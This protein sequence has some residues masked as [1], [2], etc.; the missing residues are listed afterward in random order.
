MFPLTYLLH[1]YV[2]KFVKR[3]DRALPSPDAKYTNLYMKNLD[4]DI[5]EE[6]LREKFSEFGKIASLV[7]LKD[8][9]GTSRG[10]GFVNF[11]NPDDA[12]QAMEAVHGKQLGKLCFFSDVCFVFSPSIF[13]YFFFCLAIYLCVLFRRW[14]ELYISF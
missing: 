9:N 3:S 8:D 7:I 14:V 13:I 11:E 1:R 6:H 4:E 5:N 2:T 10:F 12:R